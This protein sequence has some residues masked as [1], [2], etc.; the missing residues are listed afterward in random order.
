[1]KIRKKIKMN[2]INRNEEKRKKRKPRNPYEEDRK[3]I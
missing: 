2:E 3:P 1:M